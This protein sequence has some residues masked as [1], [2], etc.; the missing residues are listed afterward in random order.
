MPQP[1]S[2]LRARLVR[3]GVDL[4]EREGVGALTLREIARRAGV[5]HGAPRRHFPTH[6]ALLAAIA[7]EGYQQLGR[8]VAETID[9]AEADAHHQLLALG[10]LYLRFARTHHGMFELMF[11]HDLLRGNGVGLRDASDQLFGVLVDLVARARPD[12]AGTPAPPVVAG[13]LWANLH[14]I[15][16]LWR[17]GSLQLM[18]RDDDVEPLL[19]A[20]LDAHLGRTTAPATR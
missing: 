14:G 2:T 9:D 12:L 3:A 7:R 20:A 18:V 11:R 4:L 8:E 6:L 13:A 15:A 16:A 1:D 17:W 19:H 5:S 10:R